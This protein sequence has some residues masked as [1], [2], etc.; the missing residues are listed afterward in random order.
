MDT[1][2]LIAALLTLAAG[3]ITALFAAFSL[4]HWRKNVQARM[5]GPAAIWDPQVLADPRSGLQASLEVFDDAIPSSE[6]LTDAQRKASQLVHLLKGCP[7]LV[8]E[9]VIDDHVLLKVEGSTLARTVWIVSTDESIEFEYPGPAVAFSGVVLDN[10]RRGVLYRYF[11]M[12]TATTRERA[13][14]LVELTR[15]EGFEDQLQIRF[16]PDRY[17]AKLRDSAD[18]LIVFESEDA[19]EMFY[20]FPAATPDGVRKWIKAPISDSRARLWDLQTTWEMAKPADE[21]GADPEQ[22]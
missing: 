20:R 15:G 3:A 22:N 12:E 10:L 13:R 4:R 17:W 18:E 9:E 5:E 11:V 16:L 6:Q 14:K 1:L 19:G 7:L 2:A 21:P 8:I